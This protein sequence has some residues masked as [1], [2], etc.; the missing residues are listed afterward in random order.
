MSGNDCGTGGRS[1]PFL[2]ETM[3]KALQNG[4]VQR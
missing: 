4:E 3:R 2:S 1:A